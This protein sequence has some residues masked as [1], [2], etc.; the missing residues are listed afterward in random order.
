[1]RIEVALIGLF[2]IALMAL[3]VT[4][5]GAILEPIA[6]SRLACTTLLGLPVF[7][8]LGLWRFGSAK[9]IRLAG[10]FWQVLAVLLIYESMKHLHANRITEWLG[11]LPKDPWMIR[12]DEALFGRVLPLRLEHWSTPAFNDIMWF[13]YI[14]VYYVGPLVALGGA[15][16]S[17]DESLALKLRRALVLGLLGG[18]VVYLVVPVAGPLFCLGERF[19]IPM[20]TQPEVGRL[21]FDSLR[22]NWDCFPSLHT[23]IPWTLTLVAWRRLPRFGKV[24]AIIA[25]SGVTLSTVVLRFHYGIDVIAGLVWAGLVAVAVNRWTW[26][27]VP[28]VV[29]WPLPQLT[30]RNRGRRRLWALALTFIATGC[31]GL[32]AEQAFEK[33]LSV[34]LG[35]STPAAAV[36]LA[37]YFLGLSLGAGAYGLFARRVRNPLRIFALLEA[38]VATWACLLAFAGVRLTAELVP[39]LR[40]SPDNAAKLLASR[41][42]VAC[43][44]ILP[45]TTLMGAS[46]PAMVDSL[47]LLRVPAPKRSMSRFYT[48]NLAGA[49]LGSLMGPYVTFPNWGVDGTL[50][51]CVVLDTTACLVVFLLS[52]ERA[53]C[54]RR[55]ATSAGISSIPWSQRAVVLSVLALA[56]GFLLFSMEVLWTHLMS[57]VLGNSVYSFAAMLGL[58][59]LGLWFG[60]ALS[61][62]TF[63][64]RNSV[65][66]WTLGCAYGVAA[67]LLVIQRLLWPEVPNWFSVAGPS[68]VSFLQAEVFRWGVAAC[69]VFP[70]AT[71][72]G[73]I[74]PALFRLEGYPDHERARLA[75]AIGSANSIGCIA[76]A[77]LTGFWLIPSMGSER[78][79]RL[80]TALCAAST[81]LLGLTLARRTTRVSLLGLA[82]AGGVLS[83]LGPRWDLL[84]LTSGQHM[85]FGRNQVWP[86]SRLVFF[87]ED[88]LGG[89]T[90]VVANP[91]GVRGQPKPYLTLL[92]NGKFQ[93]NDAWESTAQRGVTMIPLLYAARFNRACVIGLGTGESAHVPEAVGFEHVDI[94]E[95]APGIVRAAT[96]FRGAN[97]GV[98]E[99]SNVGL[100]LEDGRN[101]LLLQPELRCDLMTTE[102]S[103]VWFAGSTNLY[104]REF[105]D[106]ARSRLS[107]GGI[108]QQWI[109]IHHIGVDELGTV[110]A[111]ARASFNQVSFWVF[112]GQ[113][114]LVCSEQPQ[115]LSVDAITR[116]VSNAWQLN[117]SEAEAR[118]LVTAALSSRL[119]TPDDVDALLSNGA[120]VIN[121]DANRHLE[122]AAFR[123][124]VSKLDHARNNVKTL[125]S[126]ARFPRHA[127]PPGWSSDTEALVRSADPR[128]VFGVP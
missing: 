50:I 105:F 30:A 117:L 90:T 56:S 55:R 113:G 37:V 69:L 97:G 1:V 43:I 10:Y 62:S 39:L 23:A 5:D 2:F 35:A 70:P 40:H 101:W 41:A 59:L 104:S 14:W 80:F 94:A 72:L 44:W 118:S 121:T 119:L 24:S 15:W 123:Y 124:N 20:R 92:T 120:F 93:G 46:F 17:G 4:G 85:Y 26:M 82:C 42:L 89:M 51:F 84:T 11:I 34:M 67:L 27:D 32:L 53:W 12:V 47:E 52:R 108:F 127:V 99:R 64:N 74:Y 122:Y 73:F 103:S 6:R 54:L 19:S 100:H 87:D 28:L 126:H 16:L 33:L 109:Q 22:Y 76:G 45:P 68:I 116:F 91:A 77:L 7:L 25:A 9:A 88:T 81:A 86:Q 98:L 49:V 29:H 13:F 128:S 18:Y 96:F 31:A 110:I 75:G 95:I 78:S 21:V 60:G 8:L 106:L 107:P 36:V 57:T 48:L 71:A 38:G 3:G 102:I 79:L 125:L 66:A 83:L 65:P 112:G 114:I 115:E 63:P 61:T 111:T 58:V